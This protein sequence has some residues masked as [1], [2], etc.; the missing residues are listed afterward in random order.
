MIGTITMKVRLQTV[1]LGLKT[2]IIILLK[3]KEMPYCGAVPGSTILGSAVPRFATSTTATSTTSILVFVLS[4]RS[5]GLFTAR[6][7]RWESVE[8]ATEESSL[9]L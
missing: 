6:V 7:G 2:I 1:V 4:A 3:K 9:H 8:S 5:G